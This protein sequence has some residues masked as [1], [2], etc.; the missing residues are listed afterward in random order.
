LALAKVS[1]Q[2]GT[3]LIF[4]RLIGPYGSQGATETE[5]LAGKPFDLGPKLGLVLKQQALKWARSEASTEFLVRQRRRVQFSD[6]TGQE[7]ARWLL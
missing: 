3:T 7:I 6:K 2:G 1:E 4:W 5:V